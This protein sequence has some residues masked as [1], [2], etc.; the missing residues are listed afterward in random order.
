MHP[1]SPQT[2]YFGTYRVWKTTNKGNSWTPISG[3]LT[4]NLAQSGFS[5]ITTIAISKLNPNVLLTGSDDGRVHVSSSGGLFWQDISQGL[6]QRWIT[7]VAFDPFEE[8]TIYTTVSGFRWD[9]PHPYVFRSTNLGQTWEAISSNLPS[10]PVNVI[11]ADPDRL[12]WLYVGTDVGVFYTENYGLEWNSLMDGMPSVPVIDLKIHQPTRTLFA[13]T[14]GNSA[15]R[16]NLDLI[17]SVLPKEKSPIFAA[18]KPVYPNPVSKTGVIQS[19]YYLT[20]GGYCE[21]QLLDIKGNLIRKIYSG[22]QTSGE[23]QVSINLNGSGLSSDGIFF[24]RL[25]TKS[26]SYQQ[27]F[28]IN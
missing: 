19:S 22:N 8:N 16:L 5:T 17:T 4:H 14:Y 2:L 25:L 24:L 15:H 28:I 6:P 3:D 26:N 9:E 20:T 18:L 23:H 11:V 7:R 13:G 10:L 27:K 1:T 21:L 12:G